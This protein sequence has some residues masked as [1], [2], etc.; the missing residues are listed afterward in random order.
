M[1]RGRPARTLLLAALLGG[2]VLV[3]ACG[4]GGGAPPTNAPAELSLSSLADGTPVALSD[5]RGSPVLLTSWATWCPE[6]KPHLPGLEMLWRNRH[7]DGL[8]VIAV[9]IDGPGINREIQPMVDAMGLTMPVWRD[10]HHGFADAFGMVGVPSTVLLDRDGRVAARWVGATEFTG[11]SV[12]EA[13]DA[14]LAG[15]G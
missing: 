13:V 2:V 3:S 9:N 7:S 4:G 15:G 5:L 12:T 8:E 1:S 10:P 14:V 11:T 6:C